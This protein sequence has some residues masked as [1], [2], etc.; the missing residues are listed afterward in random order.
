M[1]KEL[2]AKLTLNVPVYN[3]IKAMF[4][5]LTVPE[6]QSI[7]YKPDLNNSKARRKNLKKWLRV[8]IN[9]LSKSKPKVPSN[10]ILKC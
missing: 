8:E 4:M 1:P 6:T 10:V 9:F 5:F 3:P 2:N 7:I